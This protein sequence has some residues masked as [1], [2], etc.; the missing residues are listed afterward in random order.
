LSLKRAIYIKQRLSA[1][2]PEVGSRTRPQ[3][4]GFKENIVGSGTDD[5]VDAPDRRVEFKIRDCRA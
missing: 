1:E 2:S 4:M 3:G 5:L